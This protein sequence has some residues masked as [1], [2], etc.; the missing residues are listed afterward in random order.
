[1]MSTS[2]YASG[3]E[4]QAPVEPPRE[5]AQLTVMAAVANATAPGPSASQP[6]SQ[7]KSQ[8]GGQQKKTGP[9]N[10]NGGGKAK[11]KYEFAPNVGTG[12]ITYQPK[13]RGPRWACPVKGH[14]GHTIAQC[15]D[16]WGAE[17]CLERGEDCW[18]VPAVTRV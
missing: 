15:S 8:G 12:Q 10:G 6:S 2:G 13:V 18:L 7:P 9:Q 17:N 4:S 16:F 3:Q 11:P 5:P 14:S 1:M